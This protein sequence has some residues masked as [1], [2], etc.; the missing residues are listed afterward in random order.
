[1]TKDFLDLATKALVGEGSFYKRGC[2]RNG[3]GQDEANLR[4]SENMAT[5]KLQR[6]PV[7]ESRGHQEQG[8]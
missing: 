6:A 4:H 5:T 3:G 8:S 1:M 7:L 2:G